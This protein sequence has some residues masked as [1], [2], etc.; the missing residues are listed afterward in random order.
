MANRTCSIE[1]CGR[2]HKARGFCN[3]HYYAAKDRGELPVIMPMHS[4][5]EEAFAA[6]TKRDAATGC[7]IWIGA[8][9]VHGYGRLGVH[10]KLTRAHRYAW[11]RVNGP[12]PDGMFLDHMCYRPECTEVSHLRLAT[13]QE[14]AQNRSGAMPGSVTGVRGVSPNKRGF[15]AAVRKDGKSHRGG[16]FSTIEEADSVA[17]K[18][19]AELFGEFAGRG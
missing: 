13:P 8:R 4:D 2:K 18:L 15:R 17:R 5:P 3:S 10:G 11:E 6:R 12:I 1:G 7:L 19:R 14:N 16:T 9:E